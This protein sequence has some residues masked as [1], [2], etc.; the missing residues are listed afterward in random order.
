MRTAFALTVIVVLID[1]SFATAADAPW[2][3]GTARVEITPSEPVR[4]SGYGNRD[5]PHEGVDVPLFA[6]AVAIQHGDA[7][8]HVIVSVDTIG[9]P[10]VLTQEIHEAIEERH[11]LPRANFVVTCTHSHTAPHIGRG[12]NN[13]FSKPLTDEE[14]AKTEAYTDLVRDRV[15]ATVDGALGALVPCRLHYAE[16][17]AGFAVNRR[18]LQDGV[19]TGFGINPQ[20]PVDHTLPILRV[21][22][23]AGNVKAVLFNY[24]CHC[25]TFGGDY[26]RVNGDWAGYAAEYLEQA[27]PGA[28]ALCTIGCGADA[29][30]E[31]DSPRAFALAQSQGREIFDEVQRLLGGAMTEITAPIQASYGFAGL[32]SDRPTREELQARLNDGSPQVRRH[33]ETMLDVW[34]RMGRLPETYPMPIQVWRFADQFTMVF[35]GGEVCVDYAF[36]IRRELGHAEA[37]DAARPAI[38]TWVTAYANDV[39]GYVASER[40]RAEGG[41]EVDFSMIYYLQPGRWSTGTEEVILRRVHELYE[42]RLP[43]GPLSVEDALRQF[44]LPPGYAISV[45]AA[46][47]LITDPVNFAVGPDGRLWVVEMG[48]YPRGDPA[49]ESDSWD[50]RP[51][52]AGRIRVLS[53]VDR[54]GR[55]DEAVTF[56]DRLNFPTGVFPWRDGALVACAP[57]IFFARDDDGDGRA[58]HR[59]VLYTG[60]VESNPQHRINGFCY[61]LDGWLYLGSGASSGDITCTLTGEIVNVAGRDSR[62]LPDAGLLE[63]ESG[64]TQYG[65]CRDDWGNWFGNDNSHPL[66]QFVISDRYLARNPFVAAPHPLVHVADPPTAP[67]VYPTSRTVDRFNDLFAENRFTS[68]CSPI[69]F[70]DETLGPDV[71]GAALICEP[72]H[73]LVSRL[74]LEPDGV[75]FRGRRHD[76]EQAA[77]FLS[78]RDNWFRP[79][80][81]TTG[82]DGTLWVADMYRQ[83]IEHPEWIPEAWQERLN[84]YAGNDRGRIYRVYR[85]AP[86]NNETQRFETPD[87]AAMSERE[88][89][90]ELRRSNGWRRDTAQLLLIQRGDLS[91]E[92]AGRLAALLGDSEPLARLHALCVLHGR[93]RLSAAAVRAALHD[94][95]PRV[96]RQAL[97]FAEPL[98]DDPTV[99]KAAVAAAGHGDAGVRL[100]AA[101]SLGESNSQEAAEALARLATSADGDEWQRAAVLSSARGKAEWMLATVLRGGVPTEARTRLIAP[102][103]ATALGEDPAAGAARIL[104]IIGTGNGAATD[105]WQFAALGAVLEALQ[106]EGIDLDRLSRDNPDLEEALEG[107][108]RIFERARTLADDDGAE[109]ARRIAA[110]SVLARRSEGAQS[111]RELLTTWLN[112]QSSPELQAAAV[113]ALARTA[114]EDV[115]PRLLGAW[116]NAAPALRSTILQVLSAREPWTQ[117]LLAALESGA[118]SVTEL[119]AATRNRLAEHPDDGLRS[120]AQALLGSSSSADRQEIV[121]A[122]QGVLKL[123][124]DAEQGEQ[125]FRQRC[126]ACHKLNGIGQEVG[127]PLA[128]LQNK[129]TEA[130]LTAILDPNRATEAKFTAYSVLLKDGRVL[131][132]LIIEETATSLTLAKADGAR[133]VLLR[134]DIDELAGS[135]KSFMPEGLERDLSPQQLADVIAYIQAAA[136]QPETPAP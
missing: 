129:S 24:A 37:A 91:D 132:G 120:R 29:N 62:I 59:T 134:V 14:R 76:T 126:A 68:A 93:Q 6:R 117:E 51:E 121:N 104:S 27:H 45:V 80:R 20:G 74:I 115:P 87:L 11:G 108:E 101:L 95:D 88:L 32:P 116:S 112:P 3:C 84:L 65:R 69:V 98:L 106:R 119:D 9:F 56:L 105:D 61:G 10:G 16:G 67:P 35:L 43:E 38:P 113:A 21:S 110:A 13:L 85:I 128:A 2:R 36:R 135:G 75:T 42:N 109:L 130:L 118:L 18:V 48:D 83:V 90:E 99:L 63:A 58:D 46:E 60:F 114:A 70:R 40:M 111:D 127:A 25:T 23:D 124:A 79:T 125:V 64:E 50:R 92:A 55:Y 5:R 31:R 86:N 66:F 44:T 57:D 15:I 49:H 102:L 94:P 107:V 39:F 7:A 100:Q 96:V 97:E 73:N 30:P 41:Y 133:D 103:V 33:A 78:S 131:N 77:E 122:H 8:A 17:S 54:D 28:V 72:V 4:L 81:L 89:M 53:D 19:W 52:P 123:K 136:A 82:P 71:Q 26:N 47:P 1:S 22:D 34:D 12:L